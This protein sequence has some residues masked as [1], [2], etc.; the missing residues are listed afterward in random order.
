MTVE[1]KG[2]NV[3]RVKTTFFIVND[4]IMDYPMDILIHAKQDLDIEC[5]DLK[6]RIEGLPK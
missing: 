3:F 5:S 6:I 2:D 4:E 1:S